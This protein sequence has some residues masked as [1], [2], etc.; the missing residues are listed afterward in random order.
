MPNLRLPLVRFMT[1]PGA[2]VG[3]LYNRSGPVQGYSPYL[4]YS[5]IA[6][7]VQPGNLYLSLCDAF[8][9]FFH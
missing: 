9:A 8:A 2:R 5:K 4:R 7:C 3:A 1:H 6:C